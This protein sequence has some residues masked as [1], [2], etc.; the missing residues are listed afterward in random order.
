MKNI[1]KKAFSLAEVL[2]A[3][4]IISIIATMMVSISRKGL[5]DAYNLYY[6]TG[7]KG[8]LDAISY[9]LQRSNTVD[10][11][12][13]CQAMDLTCRNGLTANENYIFPT[14]NGITYRRISTDAATGTI[15]ITMNIPTAKGNPTQV[16]LYYA[17]DLLVPG[18]ATLPDGRTINLYERRDL[19]PFYID[20]GVTGRIR[21]TVTGEIIPHPTGPDFVPYTYRG[22]TDTYCAMSNNR[23]DTNT[24][25]YLNNANKL[26]NAIRN[27]DGDTQGVLKVANPRKVF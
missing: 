17:N 5:E 18:R 12:L 23:F 2:I 11:N 19:L 7:Y 3:L 25:N 20:D 6:Y 13:I 21:Q 4:S 9:S 15:E 16:T 1:Y 24:R 26:N 22:F 10:N 27:C 8:M 14:K